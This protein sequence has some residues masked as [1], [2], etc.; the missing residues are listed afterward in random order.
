MSH[1]GQ[2]ETSKMWRNSKVLTARSSSQ[3]GYSLS[4]TLAAWGP[5]LLLED[6][7]YHDPYAVTC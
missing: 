5:L 4:P 3:D 6:S 2:L 1:L 7:A